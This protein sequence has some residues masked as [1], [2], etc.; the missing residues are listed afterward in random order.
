T[1]QLDELMDMVRTK[2]DVRFEPLVVGDIALEFLQI[3]D[4]AALLERLSREAG[5]ERLTLPLWAR[6]WPT[7]ILLSYYLRRVAPMN[8][9]GAPKKLLELGAGV[10]VCG[11]FAAAMGFDVTLT[12]INPDAQLF[13]RIN[14]LKNGL[15]GRARALRVDFAADR[16]GCRFDGIVGSEILYLEDLHRP[17]VK[18]L[19]AHLALHPE[20]EVLLAREYHRKATTFTRRAVREFQL[21]E[22][23]LGYRETSTDG[24]PKSGERRLAVI[25]RMRARKHA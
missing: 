6:I 21:E 22:K 2:Y 15:S 12:D 17:L 3:S 9:S 16:L 8:D 24:D 20:A 7:A 14:I 10:G 19:T 5:E 25:T 13:T 18:F 11:L 23:I 1:A 4:M